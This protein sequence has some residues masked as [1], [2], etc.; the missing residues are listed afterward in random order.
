MENSK[1]TTMC[2]ALLDPFPP[3]SHAFHAAGLS[4]AQKQFPPLLARLFRV[5]IL[6]FKQQ[7]KRQGSG[8]LVLLN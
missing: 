6:Q 7:L 4:N 3:P 5:I 2:N 1:M 8:E